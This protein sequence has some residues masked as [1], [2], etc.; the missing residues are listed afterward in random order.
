M[1]LSH[2]LTRRAA[3]PT[4]AP[5]EGAMRIAKCAPDGRIAAVVGDR[6]VDLRVCGHVSV[7]D[8]DLI[9]WGMGYAVRPSWDPGPSAQLLRAEV[10]WQPSEDFRFDIRR[11]SKHGVSWDRKEPLTRGSR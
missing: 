4:T 8:L 6:L 1:K 7:G 3:G 2:P 10:A 5:R 9:D 11:G